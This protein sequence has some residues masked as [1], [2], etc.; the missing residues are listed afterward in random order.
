MGARVDDPARTEGVEGFG[1]GDTAF[2]VANAQ[3]STTYLTGIVDVRA[4][5]LID[6]VAGRGGLAR[7]QGAVVTSG[8][9][10]CPPR[11]HARGLSAPCVACYDRIGLPALA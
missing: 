9:G 8:L 2:L 10:G 3:H 11:C 6:V 1:V 4:P 7:A 5:R